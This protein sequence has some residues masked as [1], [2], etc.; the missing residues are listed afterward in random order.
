VSDSTRSPSPPDR[1]TDI[2]RRDRQIPWSAIEALTHHD[3]CH[4]GLAEYRDQGELLDAGQ[5]RAAALSLAQR[6]TTVGV[7]TGFCV[8]TDRGIAAETDGPPG[9]LFLAR[10]LAACGHDV[11]LLS[12]AH[13]LPLLQAGK[14][15]WRLERVLLLELPFESP[16]DAPRQ[17]DEVL[18][19][20]LAPTS[21]AALSHLVAIERPGPSHTLESL[22]SQN[23]IGPAPRTRFVESVAQHSRD[24]CHSMR[25]EPI[26]EHAAPAFRLFDRIAERG[27]PIA[28]IGIGDGGNEIGMGRFAWE[29]LV[30]AIPSNVATRIVSRV[31]TDFAL[32]G[33]TSDWAAY[34]LA[35][36]FAALGG[37]LGEAEAWTA[38]VQAAL[39]ERLVQAGAVDGITHRR[40]LTVDGLA[41]DAYLEPLVAMRRLL[42][43]EAD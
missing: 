4:R 28:T 38:N 42:G 1:P 19:A 30:D 26:D 27:L 20:I 14:D 11:V 8:V 10:A 39:L 40:E 24:R 12:D 43:L 37:R 7:V 15:L 6:A 23:R 16:A 9:A 18:D 2:E 34:A 17:V 36:S 41:L 21:A 3:P 35:L 33:G 13:G 25:G 31:A 5:L 32:V 29:T 22:A